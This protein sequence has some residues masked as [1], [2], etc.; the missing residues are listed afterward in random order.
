MSLKIK[1]KYEPVTQSIR[2]SIFSMCVATMHHLNYSG[3]KSRKQ[4]AVYDADIPVTLK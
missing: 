3:Q 2:N 1:V 4:L